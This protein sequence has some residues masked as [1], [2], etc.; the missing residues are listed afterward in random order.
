MRR[1]LPLTIVFMSTLLAF[2][3]SGDIIEDDSFT[4]RTE[5]GTLPEVDIVKISTEGKSANIECAIIS[6]GTADIKR[7]GIVY[8]KT[9]K[10]PIIK[11]EG[12]SY[13]ALIA[14][15]EGNFKGSITTV[16]VDAM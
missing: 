14:D 16:T 11:G 5:T 9:N 2:A 15:D 6:E 1:K 3:C 10:K 4:S 12:C 13:R 8:S 7:T